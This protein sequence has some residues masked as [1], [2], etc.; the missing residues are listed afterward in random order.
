[1]R[2][3]K[4]RRWTAK[5]S[6]KLVIGAQDLAS[7]VIGK[8]KAST[9]ALGTAAGV[10]L[11]RGLTAAMNAL[12]GMVNDVLRSEEAN[13][14][15]DA[16]LRGVG[17]YTP[18]LAQHY[19]DLASAIQDETGAVDENVK[20][21]IA[22]LTTMGVG[23]D[24]MDV[25]AR[26]VQSLAALGRDGAEAAVAVGRAVMGDVEAFERFA[27]EVRTASTLSEKYAAINR[28]LAAGYAQ[29]EANLLTVGGAW[30]ALK[31]R[32]GDAIEDMGNA[33]THG[34]RLGKTFN[35][36]QEAM[37]KFLQS[38]QWKAFTDRIS[39]AAGNVAEIVKAMTVS[40][41][42]GAK[43]VSKAIG[44]VILAALQDGADYVGAKISAAFGRNKLDDFDP[45]LAAAGR[46][47]GAKSA[48]ASW[49]DA[50]TAMDKP[51]DEK[52]GGHLAVALKKLEHTVNTINRT[53]MQTAEAGKKIAA[54]MDGVAKETEKQKKPAI[55]IS[56]AMLKQE[57]AYYNTMWA[58]DSIAAMKREQ[59]ATEKRITKLA[60]EEEKLRRDA[61]GAQKAA[62]ERA[63]LGIAGWLEKS[64]SDN[65][66]LEEEQKREKK[67]RDRINRL[68]DMKE[69]GAHLNSYELRDL[70]AA[71]RQKAQ[72]EA[73]GRA[74]ARD[75]AAADELKKQQQREKNE[76]KRLQERIAK[77][78]EQMAKDLKES[79]TV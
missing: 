4:E 23:A 54:D 29:Q 68:R 19:R 73:L 62:T 16:A 45:K 44:N 25:A 46:F 67:A 33:V 27:P 3:R 21:T 40:D 8:V 47:W 20:A 61:A 71:D 24:K 59:E 28:M 49:G 9:I 41:G 79:V 55:D 18:Q 13:V 1:M 5:N 75:L 58:Q 6:I 66:S 72:I 26:A 70:A 64:K 74:K 52:G 48:G 10:L 38:E 22:Q 35:D 42:A 56:E 60:A 32:I 14:K 57:E 65:K 50:L 63:K 34:L 7:G 36:A 17:S 69:K 51:K 12:R 30:A 77:A 37:G 31:G 11:A 76:S 2:S 43:D 53:Y 15:L 39:N 78:T